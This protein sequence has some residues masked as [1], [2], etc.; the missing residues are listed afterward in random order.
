MCGS[1]GRGVE[2]GA[3]R[4]GEGGD[5]AGRAG[6]GEVVSADLDLSGFTLEVKALARGKSR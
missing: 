4:G 3:G 6:L 2:R 1:T 5:A